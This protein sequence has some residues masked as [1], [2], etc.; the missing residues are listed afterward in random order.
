ME[1]TALLRTTNSIETSKENKMS[2]MTEK[3]SIQTEPKFDHSKIEQAVKLMFEAIGEDVNRP[4]IV[5]TPDRVARAFEEMFEG[6][7]YTNEE[8]AEA[9]KVLFDT[10]SGDLVVEEISGPGIGSVCEHHLL[11][12]FDSRVFVGYI[13][14]GKVIGLSKLARIV[15]LCGHRPGLQE[16]WG[17]DVA[18]CVMKATGSKDVA[19]VIFSKHGCIHWRGA[20]ADVTTKTAALEGRFKEDIALRSEFYNL[21]KEK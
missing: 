11:P 16:R 10:E 15:Q 20:K 21:T 19:V 12:M 6:C 17:S 9:N 18:E 13:P 3:L 2:K 4:G 1:A 8:I 14:N 7:K 5:G